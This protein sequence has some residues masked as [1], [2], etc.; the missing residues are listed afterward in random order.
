MLGRLTKTTT[1]QCL[2]MLKVSWS[3]LHFFTIP[4]VLL[5]INSNKK[6]RRKNATVIIHKGQLSVSMKSG[7]TYWS[8]QKLSP[9]WILWWS[10]QLRWKQEM[11]SHYKT[12]KIRQ[13][14]NSLNLMLMPLIIPKMKWYAPMN[15]DNCCLQIDILMKVSLP[16]KNTCIYTWLLSKYI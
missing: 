4:N 7:T 13:E 15:E 8:I 2:N 14:K 3:T 5:L 10:K 6:N 11:E 1:A 9:I 16:R 12:L